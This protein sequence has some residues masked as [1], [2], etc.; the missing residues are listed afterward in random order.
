MEP[1]TPRQPACHICG[2]EVHLLPCE[3]CPCSDVPLNGIYLT[4]WAH[5]PGD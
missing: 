5:G 4:P 2:D 1:L 3:S